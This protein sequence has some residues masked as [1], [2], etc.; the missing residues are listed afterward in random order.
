[1]IEPQ[2]EA[3]CTPDASRREAAPAPAVASPAADAAS[4]F[5]I[6][7]AGRSG[8]TL[9]RLMLIAH[10]RIEI[11]PETWFVSE[12]VRRLPIREVL[13]PAEVARAVEIMTAD[14]RWPDM[15]MTAEA[16]R[17]AAAA[18]PNPRLVDV[19]DIV[20]RHH[21]ASSGKMRF[22]DKT[23]RYIEIV[24]QLSI[25]YPGAK[26]I[27]LVRDGR[28]VAASIIEL[29]WNDK[30]CRYYERDFRW[31]QVLRQREQL[32]KSDLDRNI[33]DVRYEE[34]VRAPEET[35]WRI[36][37]FLGEEFEPAMIDSNRLVERVPARERKIHPK[38]E[39]RLSEE[40][41]AAWRTKLSNLECFAMEACLQ[42]D[43]R[44]W[45]YPLRYSALLWKPL[46]VAAGWLLF[47]VGPLLRRIVPPLK[48]R[49]YLPQGI[50]I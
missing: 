26:F 35:M 31:T 50:Y 21:L 19:I 20:Y 37:A 42:K 34:L 27:H 15:G 47:A 39:K 16:L 49:N 4:P 6:V 36:C 1:M 18:L 5:F 3:V 9:L 23:P 28:D 2:A 45:G 32:G 17:Q 41:I 44:R 38:L 22:G 24:P 43:L 40:A 33:L 8:T 12:L 46:L 10:S 14:Y 48:R 29:N 11:P 13:A 7:G 25:L 30:G